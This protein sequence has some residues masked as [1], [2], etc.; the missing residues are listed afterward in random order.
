MIE[1]FCQIFLITSNSYQSN[2]IIYDES[3]NSFGV[4]IMGQGSLLFSVDYFK[5]NSLYFSSSVI[6]L[7]SNAQSV[8]IYVITYLLREHYAETGFKNNVR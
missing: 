7:K 8:L 3:L 5:L 6:A 1:H 4:P 2:K